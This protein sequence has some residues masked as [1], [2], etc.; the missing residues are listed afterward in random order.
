MQADGK[1]SVLAFGLQNTPEQLEP[2]QLKVQGSIPTWL[3]GSLYRTGPGTYD[4]PLDNGGVYHVNYWFNGY[5]MNVSLQLFSADLR[6]LTGM[7]FTAQVPNQ[8]RR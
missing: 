8:R 2:I 7:R 5:G 1:T 3:S 4:I 6:K